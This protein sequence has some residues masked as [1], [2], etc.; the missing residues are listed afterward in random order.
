MVERVTPG[1]ARSASASSQK[2][3]CGSEQ[4]VMAI[5]VGGRRELADRLGGQGRGLGLRRRP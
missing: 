1:V 5:K 4:S 2:R 3:D